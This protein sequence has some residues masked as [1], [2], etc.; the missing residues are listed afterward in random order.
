M[1]IWTSL[2]PASRNRRTIRSDVVPLTIESSIRMTRLSLTVCAI[3]LSLILT[4]FSRICCVGAMKLRPMYL[5]FKK[6]MP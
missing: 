5:F 6:P 2:A 3:T 4:A 1:R